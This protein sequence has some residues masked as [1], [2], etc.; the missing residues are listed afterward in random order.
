MIRRESLHDKVVRH[1][2]LQILRGGATTLPNEA[3]LGKE[4]RVSRSILRESIKVLAAKGLLEVGPKTGTRVRP[5]KDWN[6][7]DPQLLEWISENGI[8]EHFFENLS[9]LRSILEPKA[10]ELA[11]LR[12]TE[13]DIEEMQSAWEGMRRNSDHREAYNAADLRFHQTILAASHNELLYQVGGLVRVLLRMSFALTS[14]SWGPVSASL[15]F[16]KDVMDAIVDRNHVA[17]KKHMEGIIALA[18]AGLRKSLDYK[19]HQRPSSR[20]KTPVAAAQ[21]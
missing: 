11:A 6:L 16:H 17:A 21:D 9:E 13:S 14:A 1:L 20:H 15:P 10:A 5:R 12:A 7:L 3:D 8:E 4:L 18:T 2:A 19:A